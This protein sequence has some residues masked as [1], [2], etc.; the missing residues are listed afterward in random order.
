MSP[1]PIYPGPHFPGFEV[2]AADRHRRLVPVDALELRHVVEDRARGDAAAPIHHAALEAAGF[3]RQVL[4]DRNA[5]VHLPV[6]EE[7]APGVDMRH[8]LPVVAHLIVVG[9]AALGDH[10]GD[11][12]EDA[13]RADVGSD[14]LRLRMGE[15]HDGPVAHQPH[16]ACNLLGRDEI[17]GALRFLP[18]RCPPAPGLEL[19][20][21]LVV[22]GTQQRGIR[23]RDRRRCRYAQRSLAPRPHPGADQAGYDQAGPHGDRCHTISHALLPAFRGVQ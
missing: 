6:L 14:R 17:R 4:L 12:V 1:G 22:L 19:G 18:E 7:V 21:P 16:G 2:G 9:C 10:V 3:L 23:R 13:G 20:P 11:P 8:G 15:R 5:V